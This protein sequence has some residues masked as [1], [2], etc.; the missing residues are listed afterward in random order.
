MLGQSQ[1]GEPAFGIAYL[2]MPKIETQREALGRYES[3]VAVEDYD[4]Q[5]LHA[6]AICTIETYDAY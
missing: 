6:N 4:V 1:G 3:I 5:I 2:S